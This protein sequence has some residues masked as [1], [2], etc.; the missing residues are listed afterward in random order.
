MIKLSKG[1]PIIAKRTVTLCLCALLVACSALKLL[2]NQLPT[3]GYWWLDGYFDV[4][5]QQAPELKR[6]LREVLA[7]HKTTELPAIVAL[8]NDVEQ[9]LE[10]PI[11]GDQMCGWFT[12]FEPRINAVLD[13][14]AV[15]AAPIL[16]RLTPQQ[17]TYFDK[18]IAD[19]NKE[20]REKWLDPQAD[21]L[22]D[23]RLERAIENLERVYGS[24]SREQTQAV[25]ARLAADP[26]DFER[27]WQNRLRYQTAFRGWLVAYQGRALATPE[28]K[29]AAIQS[30]QGLWRAAADWRLEDRIQTCQLLADFHGLM[31]PAQRLN[32]VKTYQGYQ[33][34]LQSLH[35]EG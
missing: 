15:M 16:A 11:T 17:L 10:K 33:K 25:K 7:W 14:T 35:F 13:R 28:A 26:F 24:V 27:S 9:H 5:D 4:S 21:D 19:K 23:A 29:Q 12:R 2:Y 3:V 32:A 30:L 1:F 22:L 18:A 20:W 8:L 31:T 34:D 6:G